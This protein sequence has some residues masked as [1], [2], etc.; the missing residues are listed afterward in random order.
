MGVI[1]N[2]STKTFGVGTTISPSTMTM[3]THLSSRFL[4][5]F[6]TIREINQN[7]DTYTWEL[8]I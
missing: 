6:G 8:N 2:L 1:A 3:V 7:H 5:P 4:A